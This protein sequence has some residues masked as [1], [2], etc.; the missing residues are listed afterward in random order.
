MINK[1][2]KKVKEMERY[3]K[4]KESHNKTNKLFYYILL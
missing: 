3:F 1:I 4:L 2:R